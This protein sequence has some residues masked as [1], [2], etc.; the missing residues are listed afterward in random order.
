MHRQHQVGPTLNTEGGVKW[1]WEGKLRVKLG[2]FVCLF[3]NLSTINIW[4]QNN[5]LLLRAVRSKVGWFS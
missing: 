1:E 3:F 5:F 2:I 4:R